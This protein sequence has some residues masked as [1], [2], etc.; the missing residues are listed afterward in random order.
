LSCG[1]AADI[2]TGYEMEDRGVGVRV[3][4]GSRILTFLYLQ[5]GSRVHPTSYRLGSRDSFPPGVKWQGRE[6][7]RSPP[8]NAEVKKT[9]I[10]KS[11]PPIHLH[12]VVLS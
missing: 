3:P 5:T 9:R 4:V 11:A 2:P 10:Y 1:R 7:D 12:G 6:A 8:T